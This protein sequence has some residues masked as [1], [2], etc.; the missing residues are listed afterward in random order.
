MVL[1]DSS[2]YSTGVTYKLDGVTK[3]YSQYTSGFSSATSRQLIIAVVAQRIILLQC[4]HSGMGGAINT[5]S[6]FGSSNFDG[7]AFNQSF[8]N[9]I[10]GFSIV[11]YTGD[12]SGSG[13]IGT[14][15]GSKPELIIIKNLDSTTD[16]WWFIIQNFRCYKVFKIK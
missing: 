1:V 5:N 13:T 7:N 4:V 11:K 10:S 2:E 14:V 8:C 9:S 12:G 16:S 6:T 3:T 15:L